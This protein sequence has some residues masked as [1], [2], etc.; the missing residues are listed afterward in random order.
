[1]H[2]FLFCGKSLFESVFETTEMQETFLEIAVRGF[3]YLFEWFIIN[4]SD[5]RDTFIMM[6]I[7]DT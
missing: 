4:P 7:A 6:R 5:R 2:F 1:M 3:L